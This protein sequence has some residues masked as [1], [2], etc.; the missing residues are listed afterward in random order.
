MHTCISTYICDRL[1]GVGF[2]YSM[3]KLQP[4]TWNEFECTYYNILQHMIYLTYT[5]IYIYPYV[6]LL[7]LHP[8]LTV[9]SHQHQAEQKTNNSSCGFQGIDPTQSAAEVSDPPGPEAAFF[10][11][12]TQ[13]KFQPARMRSLVF[14]WKKDVFF[15][16]CQVQLSR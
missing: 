8:L 10:G 2:M 5:Y 6:V 14:F 12:E 15:K 3:H 9:S 1:Q 13:P 7:I 16:G 11:Q 4:S